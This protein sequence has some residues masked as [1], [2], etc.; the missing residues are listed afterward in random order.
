MIQDIVRRMRSF[1]RRYN[2]NTLGM[3]EALVVIMR[4]Q[5]NDHRQD[6]QVDQLEVI[7]KKL[8]ALPYGVETRPSDARAFAEE[9]AVN[10]PF[11]GE[12]L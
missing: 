11:C 3:L 4:E 7:L 1:S 12:D 2:Y 10:S 5:S 8:R 9:T 6:E